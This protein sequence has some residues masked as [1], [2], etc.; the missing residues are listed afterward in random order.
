M[1]IEDGKILGVEEGRGEG[2]RRGPGRRRAGRLPRIRRPALPPEGARLRAQGDDRERHPM[3][4]AR[5]GFT[6][7]CAMP[8]TDP[9]ADSRAVVD[10]VLRKGRD[11]GAV[12]VLPIGCVTK[13]SR[14]Y[15]AL[16]DGRARGGRRRRLQRRRPARPRRERDAAG[17]DLQL[18]VRPTDHQPLRGHRAEPAGTGQ[19][20]LGVE[21]AGRTGHTG[22]RRGDHG[23]PGHRARGADR[24]ASAH[25]AREHRGHGR[26]GAA[27][28]GARDEERH[29]R[30]H[31]APSD[32]ERRDAPGAGRRVR[33]RTAHAR[34]LRLQCQGGAAA[35]LPLRRGG[36][37]ARAGRRH[38]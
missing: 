7:V 26:A 34:R 29:L 2:A 15:A 37:G 17:A 12:R 9:V 11:E 8:N 25:S 13:G 21:P 33:L 6:T 22:C 18:V 19:R 36:D 32:P 1:V 3:A 4:A 16:R 24:R 30:G 5:G 10:F 20:G 27:G 28:Q 14:R 23:S 38:R 31:P 35:A